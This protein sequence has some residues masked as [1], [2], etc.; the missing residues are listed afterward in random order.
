MTRAHDDISQLPRMG[1]RVGLWFTLIAVGTLAS[2]CADD[3]VEGAFDTALTQ[4]AGDSEGQDE[5]D[6]EADDEDDVGEDS[7]ASEDEGP[8]LDFEAAA[9]FPFDPGCEKVDVLFVIDN[10]SSM[11]DFQAALIAS[12]PGFVQGMK[13]G[14]EDVDSYHVGVATTDT[15][16]HL[17]PTC[18]RLGTLVTQTLGAGVDSSDAECGPYASGMRYMTEADD[19]E[20]KFTCAAKLGTEGSLQESQLAA[21]LAA[22][23]PENN[24]PGACNEGFIREDALLIVVLITD[25]SE[26]SPGHPGT[27]FEA[28]VEAKQ[29]IESNIVMLGIIKDDSPDHLLFIDLFTHGAVGQITAPSYDTFFADAIEGVSGACDEFVPPR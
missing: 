19:L 10:S 6:D 8:K 4:G 23:E 25:E 11:A 12:F 29:G 27:W 17:P 28:M 3:G 24:A 15:F 2:G 9:D 22:I 16:T 5:V 18:E 1:L 20:E 26:H 7:E 21:A 13:E 14:L